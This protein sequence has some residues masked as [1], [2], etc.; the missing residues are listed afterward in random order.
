MFLNVNKKYEFF[1]ILISL[2]LKLDIYN[3]ILVKTHKFN[4]YFIHNN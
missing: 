3:N 4:F 2:F 1:L